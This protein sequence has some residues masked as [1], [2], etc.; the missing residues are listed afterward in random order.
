MAEKIKGEF[1]RI[2]DP[3]TA[4]QMAKAENKYHKKTLGVIPPSKKKLEKGEKAAEDVLHKEG[5]E[6][7]FDDL[8]ESV[9]QRVNKFAEEHSS[10]RDLGMFHMGDVKKVFDRSGRITY[11]IS[12]TIDSHS[13]GKFIGSRYVVLEYDMEG[14]NVVGAWEK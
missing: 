8:P 12:G 1:G 10:A 14:D 7:S 5:V 11:K 2:K 4:H 9:Q 6:M 3:E 13:D